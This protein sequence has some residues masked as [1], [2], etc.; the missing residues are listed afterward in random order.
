MAP[1][2]TTAADLSR[3]EKVQSDQAAGMQKMGDQYN[4][5]SGELSDL[6]KITSD[7]AATVSMLNQGMQVLLGDRAKASINPTVT[8]PSDSV[9]VEDRVPGVFSLT[10]FLI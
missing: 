6:R 1:K 10:E 4:T 7:L 3:L 2:D 9:P 8:G 5:V